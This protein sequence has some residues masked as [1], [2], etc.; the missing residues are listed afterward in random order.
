[1]VRSSRRRTPFARLKQGGG[2]KSR[3][4]STRVTSSRKRA[5]PLY[6]K[7]F[8]SKR[9]GG[10]DKLYRVHKGVARKIGA[11]PS[12]V[13]EH[14]PF[15]SSSPLQSLQFD[16]TYIVRPLR[17]EDGMYKVIRY[18]SPSNSEETEYTKWIST[19]LQRFP[20]IKDIPDARFTLST[21]FNRIENDTKTNVKLGWHMTIQKQSTAYT[22]F[23][24]VSNGTQVQVTFTPRA[25][26]CLPTMYGEDNLELLKKFLDFGTKPE[27][28]IF[29][30]DQEYK[31]NRAKRFRA[32]HID[33]E[34]TH[35]QLIQ[36]ALAGDIQAYCKNG[37][38]PIW[39]DN[40]QWDDSEKFKKHIPPAKAHITVGAIHVPI[41][42][43]KDTWNDDANIETIKSSEFAPLIHFTHRNLTT[44]PK[45]QDLSK[46]QDGSVALK[47]FVNAFETN[48]NGLQINFASQTANL[49]SI[50]NAGDMGP[51]SATAIVDFFR[52]WQAHRFQCAY[53]KPIPVDKNP[54][55][56]TIF[57]DDNAIGHPFKS[58][59]K[60]ANLETIEP[61]TQGTTNFRDAGTGEFVTLNRVE[62]DK[63]FVSTIFKRVHG[64]YVNQAYKCACV[65]L[66]GPTEIDDMRY[67]Q[68][69]LSEVVGRHH[70]D[71]TNYIYFILNK[72]LGSTN[73]NDVEIVFHFDVNGT[74][75]SGDSMLGD[76]KFEF[77]KKM[78]RVMTDY[79]EAKYILRTFG[80]DLGK[81]IIAD[82][83]QLKVPTNR[84][85]HMNPWID[86]IVPYG[87]SPPDSKQFESI[88][89]NVFSFASKHNWMHGK[90]IPYWPTY[91]SKLYS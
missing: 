15:V 63:E 31:R 19:Y 56:I 26:I 18:R 73:I 91:D 38:Q 82:H 35:V 79:P 28:L 3:N 11:H 68:N 81:E 12:V 2:R 86:R 85:F 74:I 20:T 52:M 45:G 87:A 49:N 55:R 1:M 24:K 67:K 23:D 59:D 37:T 9:A 80:S 54:Q 70:N 36:I 83:Q 16:G 57:F 78:E 46:I 29:D 60:P 72:L 71:F 27:N 76:N 17:G 39:N 40:Y 14:H 66:W 47:E 41:D 10:I 5:S 90:T 89:T 6:R 13:R 25:L 51:S 43:I 21:G 7:R 42:K 88:E 84:Y 69:P 34:G 32:N 48:A 44:S 58:S 33:S 65:S 22:R 53:G 30:T 62:T 4:R 75:I 77:S 61:C 50:C 8:L 64:I